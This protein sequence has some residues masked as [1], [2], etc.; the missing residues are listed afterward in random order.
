M[1]FSTI[2]RSPRTGFVLQ[3]EIVYDYTA[4]HLQL[5]PEAIPGSWESNSHCNS[6]GMSLNNSEK[7]IYISDITKAADC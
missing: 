4:K 2:A 3:S 7:N 5:K 1:Q 6:L